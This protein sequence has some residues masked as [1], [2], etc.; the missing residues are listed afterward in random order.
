M[1]EISK[2]EFEFEFEKKL[3]RINWDN[4]LSIEQNDP[5]IIWKN[6][7]DT[8]TYILRKNYP[9]RSSN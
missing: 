3:A 1:I 5:N 8:L 7:F 2:F 4:I 6:F 9:K